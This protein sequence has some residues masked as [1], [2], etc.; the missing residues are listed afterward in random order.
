M[1]LASE[2]V[3]GP[4]SRAWVIPDIVG[5]G[6]LAIHLWVGACRGFE[7]LVYSV[8]VSR[9]PTRFSMLRGPSR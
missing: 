6:T 9:F 2:L 8:L 4:K 3:Q 5:A 1:T 7:G